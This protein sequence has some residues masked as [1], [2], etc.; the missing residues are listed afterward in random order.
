VET[1]H[2]S[3]RQGTLE[4][5]NPAGMVLRLDAR[6]GGIPLSL[7]PRELRRIERREPA[8]AGAP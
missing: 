4:S 7:A 3:R 2:G 8:A 6:E 5:W 1:I